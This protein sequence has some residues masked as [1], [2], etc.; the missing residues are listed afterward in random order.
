MT[1]ADMIRL[2]RS[3]LS[4]SQIAAQAG[5]PRATVASRLRRAGVKGRPAKLATKKAREEGRAWQ[6]MR[7]FGK[8]GV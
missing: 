3:G 1:T 8:W 5:V 4:Q 7:L 2:Y 6:R